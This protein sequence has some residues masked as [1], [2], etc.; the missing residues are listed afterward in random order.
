MSCMEGRETPMI[1]SAVL[2]MRCRVFHSDACNCQTT[3]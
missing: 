2:T 3:Q 1:F